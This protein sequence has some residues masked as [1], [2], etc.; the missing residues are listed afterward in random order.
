LG[1]TC[2]IALVASTFWGFIWSVL[3][4]PHEF[5]IDESHSMEVLYVLMPWL[6]LMILGYHSDKLY[7]KE[8]SK[9][10]RKKYFY[11]L[12]LGHSAFYIITLWKPLWRNET[13]AS[14]IFTHF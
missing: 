6:G 9:E 11:H 4:V 5:A 8:Q 7:S 14:A 13:L 12:V 3:H 1:I 10:K 2:W